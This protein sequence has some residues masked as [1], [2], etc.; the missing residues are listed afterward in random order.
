MFIWL[1]ACFS[2]FFISI[3][4]LNVFVWCGDHTPFYNLLNVYLKNLGMFNIN[5]FCHLHSFFAECF[6]PIVEFFVLRK[7]S[8]INCQLHYSS[9]TILRSLKLQ[10]FIYRIKTI[11]TQVFIA[12]KLYLLISD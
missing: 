11:N 7:Q 3:V 12:M 1:T 4:L 2:F 5:S 9:I 8:E 10:V 6:Y